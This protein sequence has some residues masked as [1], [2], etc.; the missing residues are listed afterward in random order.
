MAFDDMKKVQTWGVALAVSVALHMVVLGL[1]ISMKGCDSSGKPAVPPPPPETT[2]GRATELRETRAQADANAADVS[3]SPAPEERLD[4]PLTKTPLKPESRKTPP[5]KTETRKA[6]SKAELPKTG[7]KAPSAKDAKLLKDAKSAKE[8]EPAKDAKATKGPEPAK[9]AKS[10]AGK[11]GWTSY[12]VKP[13]D[14]LTKI[15]KQCGCSI[16]ELAKANG[17]SATASLQ[18]GQTIKIKNTVPDAE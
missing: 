1:L 16:Q 15:A 13:G 3:P 4:K 8:T 2:D 5:P 18:L 12:K 7:P 9:D 17:L 6:P 14:S 10:D 11:D